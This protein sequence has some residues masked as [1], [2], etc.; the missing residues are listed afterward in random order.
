M[1]KSKTLEL[2]PALRVLQ[3]LLVITRHLAQT[4]T[5]PEKLAQILDEADYLLTI[6]IHEGN[7]RDEYRAFLQHIGQRFPEF[8]GLEDY[9]DELGIIEAQLSRGRQAGNTS[10]FP[11]SQAAG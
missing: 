4:E 10:D 9:F 3:R 6:L 1:L 8:A 2:N 5:S 11:P 7:D